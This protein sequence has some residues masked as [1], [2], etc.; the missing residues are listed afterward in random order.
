[1]IVA[2]DEGA[3]AGTAVAAPHGS[4]VSISATS[5]G[6]LTVVEDWVIVW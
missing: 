2:D 3:P 4:G 5:P 6:R 1:M